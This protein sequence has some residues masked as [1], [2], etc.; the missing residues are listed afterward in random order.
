MKGTVITP[1][2]KLFMTVESG[3]KSPP[4]DKIKLIYATK[5]VDLLLNNPDDEFRFVILDIDPFFDNLMEVVKNIKSHFGMLKAPIIAVSQDLGPIQK[6][7]RIK[8]CGIEHTLLK[9]IN[10]ENLK[11]ILANILGLEY[12]VQISEQT[13]PKKEETPK[14]DT[15]KIVLI[16]EDTKVMLALMSNIVKSLGYKPITAENG[17]QAFLLAKTNKPDLIITD[18]MMPEVN[19]FEFIS[20]VKKDQNLKDIPIIVVSSLSERNA[21]LKALKLGANDFIAKP[22]TNR[23]VIERIE[24][25]LKR[26]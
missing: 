20:M 17:K 18:L 12:K 8:A 11:V 1:D 19:G 23:Q 3:L 9:P 15:T 14:E 26:K 10:T 6:R 21:I 5:P 22:F 7:I 4:F 2:K 25:W 13:Q 16:A 24:H